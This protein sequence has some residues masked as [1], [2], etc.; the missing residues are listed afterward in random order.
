RHTA[1]AQRARIF[2]AVAG[3]DDDLESVVCAGWCGRRGQWR[4]WGR[5]AR[6]NGGWF[7][8]RRGNGTWGL[9][10]MRRP[11]WHRR[12][13]RPVPRCAGSV[14]GRAER[15]EPRKPTVLCAPRYIENQARGGAIRLRCPQ[16][17]GWS[18]R[19]GGRRE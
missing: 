18:L 12:L 16:A 15:L 6:E 17:Q 10:R 9:Q 5:R 4:G 19:Q 3:V 11:G 13:P 14:T 2:T 8:R 7:W 1:D